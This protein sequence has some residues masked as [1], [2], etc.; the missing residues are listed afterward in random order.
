MRNRILSRT[1]IHN[2]IRRYHLQIDP[3]S[4]DEFGRLNVTGNAKICDTKLKKL[5]LTFGK[6]TGNFHCYLNLLTTLKGA[7]HTVGGDF[8]CS[9]NQLRSLKYSPTHG[10]GDFFCQE[11]ELEKLDGSPQTIHGNFNCFLNN[12]KNLK[13]GPSEVK[14]SFYAYGNQLTSVDGSPRVVGK[15]FHVVDNHLSNLVGA[16][17]SIGE[18]FSFDRSIKSINLGSSSCI[19]KQIEIQD[20]PNKNNKRKILPNIIFENQRSLSTIFKYFPYL[21]LYTKSEILNIEN[22]NCIINEIKDGLR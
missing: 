19:A 12:L 22:L 10:D 14:K 9:N 4:V 2:I 11:N 20:Q 7:P 15:S 3:F 16:P 18:L 21:E 8:N 1:E 13:N 6:V 5:P 17:L